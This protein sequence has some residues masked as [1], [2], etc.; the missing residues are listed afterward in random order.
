LTYADAGGG[1]LGRFVWNVRGVAGNGATL[2]FTLDSRAAGSNPAPSGTY[3]IVCLMYDGVGTAKMFV[4]GGLVAMTTAASACYTGNAT[5]PLRIGDTATPGNRFVNAATTG[6]GWQGSIAIYNR[7]LTTPEFRQQNYAFS[8]RDGAVCLNILCAGDSITAG[9][10]IANSITNFLAYPGRMQHQIGSFCRVTNVGVGG[11]TPNGSGGNANILTGQL[12]N[13]TGGF[14]NGY[15]VVCCV[16]GVNCFA[17]NNGT[18][19]AAT[20]EWDLL[21]QQ[22]AS[23]PD[24]LFLAGTLTPWK[25][26]TGNSNWDGTKY[27]GFNSH[28]QGYG[29]ANNM[30][31]YAWVDLQTPL[32]SSTDK[33]ALADHLAIDGLHGNNF[34]DDIIAQTFA[35][36]ILQIAMF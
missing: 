18:L 11:A 10:V 28:V 32:A 17:E 16:A 3:H 9:A 13:T 22:F 35:T 5:I 27:D 36:K 29:T 34:A 25:K 2:N 4:D 6:L 26:Y 7:I 8:L 19:A 31:N 15:G 12:T 24:V 1:S 21:P 23:R 20:A 14:D 33:Y 30:P